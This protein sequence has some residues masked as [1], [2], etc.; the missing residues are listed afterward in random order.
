MDR[1]SWMTISVKPVAR[2][3]LRSARR[4]R[5]GCG[6]QFFRRHAAVAVLV[7]AQDEH[8]RLFDELLARD[9]AV[10]VF[11]EITEL[12][13]GQGGISLLDRCKLGRVELAIVVAIG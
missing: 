7:E 11:V 9:L 8:A 3:F 6:F 1:P 13:L 5:R 10:L 4:L 12:G 2:P